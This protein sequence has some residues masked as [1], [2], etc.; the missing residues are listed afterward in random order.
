MGA[1]RD[2]KEAPDFA[3]ILPWLATGRRRSTRWSF[4]IDGVL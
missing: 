2:S 1:P 4:S 3:L